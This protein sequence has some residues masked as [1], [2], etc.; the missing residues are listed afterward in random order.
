MKF[1]CICENLFF[2]FPESPILF[3]EAS[4]KIQPSSLYTLLGRAESG[5]STLIRL[6]LNLEQPQKG[7]IEL[8]GQNLQKLSFEE[9]NTIM[10]KVGVAFQRGALFDQMTVGENLQFTLQQNLFLNERENEDRIRWYLNYMKLSHAYEKKPSELSGGMRRRVAV[11]RALIVDP[12]LAFLDEP[13]AGLDPVNTALMI[14]LIRQLKKQK[15]CT[16]VCLTSI[17]QVAHEFEGEVILIHNGNILGPQPLKSFE[18]PSP[19]LQ[20]LLHGRV[21]TR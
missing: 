3:Q 2:H 14:D 8:F 21:V 17:P 16:I 15:Q 19:D 4:F 7:Q 12:E 18:H 13:T 9:R 20:Q 1:I 5:K 10:L 6:I 11:I